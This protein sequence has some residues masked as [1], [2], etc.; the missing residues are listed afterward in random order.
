MENR[1]SDSFCLVDA[2]GQIKYISEAL[3]R[4]LGFEKSEFEENCFFS[5]VHEDDRA[6]VLK[7]LTNGVS[8]LHEHELS[9]R[10][11]NKDGNYVSFKTS[12]TL[13]QRDRLQPRQAIFLFNPS[14]D[15]TVTETNATASEQKFRT[16]FDNAYDAIFLMR[17][18]MFV[19]CN[20]RTEV[21]FGCSRDALLGRSPFDFSPTVQPDGRNSRE[22][23]LEKINKALRGIPQSFEW[24]HSR[25]DGVTFDAE[26]TLNSVEIGEETLLQAIVRDVSSRK[27]TEAE[28]RYRV[29][30]E[31]FIGSIST[32][33]INLAPE[34]IVS[35]IQNALEDIGVFADVDR[36]YIYLLNDERT[37]YELHYEWCNEG[38]ASLQNRNHS[39]ETEKIP[40]CHDRLNRFENVRIAEVNNLPTVASNE[41]AL[42]ESCDVQSTLCVP[43]R[44]GR[45]LI[46]FFGF[47][48]VIKKIH[49]TIEI[50]S[51]LRIVGEIISN[52]LE[53]KRR[54]DQLQR[55]A[56]QRK[57][58]LEVSTSLLGSLDVDDVIRQTLTI[59][60]DL[61]R[62]NECGI[63][64]YDEERDHLNPYII[65]DKDGHLVNSN[66]SIIPAGKGI[67]SSVLKNGA[68]EMV[69]NAHIDNR[70][71]YPY[72][73][74]TG[75]EHV[76]CVPMQAKN[77]TLG[78][79]TV[80]R[81]SETCFSV[82]E[83]E[84]VQLFVGYV[85]V[86]LENAQL[87]Q[88]VSRQ[89]AVT[90]AL[91]QTALT[92]VE[93]KDIKK[94]F[95]LIAEQALR[96][97]GVNRCAVFLWDESHNLFE[98]LVVITPDTERMPV[99]EELKIRA[100]Q[101]PVINA[102]RRERKPIVIQPDSDL[103]LEI[104][105]TFHVKSMLLIPFFRGETLLGG[106][107]LDDTREVKSFT[108]EDMN[109]AVGI[110]NQA[111]VAIENARLFEQLRTSEE[112]YRTLFEDSKDCVFVSTEDGKVLDMN[113]AGIELLGYES[114][115]ELQRLNVGNDLYLNAAR[116]EEYKNELNRKGYVK[117]FEAV[118]KRKDGKHI[119]CIIT[120]TAYRHKATGE[121]RFRGFIRDVTEKKFL[122]EKLRQ[123]HKMESLGQLA[124]GIA[125]DF[126]NVLGIV[127]ASLSALR[128]R[129]G[130]QEESLQKY[131]EMGEN[132]VMRG[133]DVARRLLTFS[134][135]HE[136][137]L[138][139]LLVQDV[140][141]DLV[142]VLKH[143]IEKNIAI[144]TSV[145]PDTPPFMGDHGQIY[146]MLLNLCIN[147][148]DAITE[149]FI[150]NE[151]GRICLSAEVVDGKQLPGNGRKRR[152]DSYLKLS[153]WDNGGGMSEQ[154]RQKIFDPFFTTKAKGKGT[155]LG[156]SVVYGIVQTHHGVIDVQTKL[157]AGSVFSVYL[158]TAKVE[159]V[160]PEKKSVTSIQ[161]GDETILVV[162]DEE[163]LASL[164]DEMLRSKG[165]NVVIAPDGAEALR[166]FR[167]RY[168][169][170]AAVVL[171]MGLPKLPGQAL[172]LKMK[173]IHPDVNIILA[174]GYLDNEMKEDLFTLGASA[175][176]QKPYNPQEILHSVRN[177][178]DKYSY[179]EN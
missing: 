38:I 138:H 39:I 131:V 166:V 73:R 48:S 65:V 17:D 87:Y 56:D 93:H 13:L 103:S 118:L 148:R 43:L 154:V 177:A 159:C 35:G 24:T 123:T 158:P 163:V 113:R 79:F 58:L 71:Y 51:L 104:A 54:E 81:R 63:H 134:Q 26:V 96:I 108:S 167:Q 146:Q 68:A 25:R 27:D 70:S 164:L 171:D 85:T 98:P 62:F 84:L 83:F 121:L 145:D 42:L 143:T 111:A 90:S 120:S 117:D 129:L 130:S 78:T 150:G 132:A 92:I 153:V 124:G 135:S 34:E 168:R 174:S 37:R 5:Y 109:A 178:I 40:W 74:P 30:F 61:L 94:V 139:P 119:N 105:E 151:G 115:E 91:L 60:N 126:N 10:T 64:L 144:E 122:E 69:N 23:A 142:N 46:G 32:N 59:L 149:N 125:H 100:D 82:D 31:K 33:F 170:F 21:L 88:Q 128:T 15:S 86:A 6:S 57:H 66:K 172:F 19:D 133:A 101:V 116:R 50:L 179:T 114:L 95:T 16:V 12:C 2:D 169:E 41:K 4:T 29:D 11:R 72:E 110:A 49:W 165:Y 7:L 156:L 140:L 112:K 14:S 18:D 76:L 89:H 22:K 147:A 136:I 52:A 161:G 75:I 97:T 160:V 162:E 175:F 77:R 1:Q 28:L 152:E 53:R 36:S 80:I 99:F 55:L 47:D 155:G 3:Q 176:V 44:V 106:M 107:A 173:Q 137:R 45:T 20:P 8:T 127:Q 9:L 157:G 67:V 102:I 141:K